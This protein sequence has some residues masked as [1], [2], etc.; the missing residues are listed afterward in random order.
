[1]NPKKPTPRHIKIKM[2]KVK[3]KEKILKAARVKQGL[4]HTV[5]F[6]RNLTPYPY[7]LKHQ[8]VSRFPKRLLL[9]PEH[10][11]FVNDISLF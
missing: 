10:M 2:P 11:R 3:E 7:L 5:L 9:V 1:M 4:E 6:Y 8:H